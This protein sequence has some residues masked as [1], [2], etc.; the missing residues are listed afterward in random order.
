MLCDN[1]EGSN[2]E[3]SRREVQEGGGLSISMADYVDV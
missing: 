1:I 3:G 2:G